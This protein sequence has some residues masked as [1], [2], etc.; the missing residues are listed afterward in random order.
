MTVVFVKAAMNLRLR[1]GCKELTQKYNHPTGAH[2]SKYAY[3]QP[4]KALCTVLQ[5]I[6]VS[7]K[8]GKGPICSANMVQ[9]LIS[10]RKFVFWDFHNASQCNEW[11]P[12]SR[13]LCA[14]VNF[15]LA[16]ISINMVSGNTLNC[17]IK[18]SKLIWCALKCVPA[19]L[20]FSHVCLSSVLQVKPC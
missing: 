13:K 4:F 14:I 18:S 6:L 11:R 2:S 8:F 12:L 7:I 1:F 9:H 10:W 5:K 20:A 16:S 17:Q 15:Q 19:V 3:H